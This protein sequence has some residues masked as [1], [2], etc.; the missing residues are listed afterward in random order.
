MAQV[1]VLNG[2]II[3]VGEWDYQVYQEPVAT[4]PYPG[5]G[6]APADWDS[7]IVLEERI[8]NPIP[9]GAVQMGCDIVTAN[10]G[11]VLL[12]TDYYNLRAE[13]YPP[14]SDQLDALWKGG[15]AAEEMAAI[16]RAVKDE[17]PKP[18]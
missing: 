6:I 11:R 17:Y 1:V 5:P 12:A 2:E 14:I 10:S 15:A 3:K 16:I 4:T 7:G 8:G 18:D 9:E 13:A